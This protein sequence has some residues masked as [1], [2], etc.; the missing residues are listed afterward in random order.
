MITKSVIIRQTVC[1]ELGGN[2][3]EVM[4]GKPE[5]VTVLTGAAA[6]IVTGKSPGKRN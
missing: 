5:Y 1:T 6:L 2:A 4:S 3:V